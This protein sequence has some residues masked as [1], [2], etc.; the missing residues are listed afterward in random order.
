MEFAF[1][2]VEELAFTSVGAVCL[3]PEEELP[4]AAGNSQLV[5]ASAHFGLVF[6]ADGLGACLHAC[7]GCCCRQCVLSL[8]R[9]RRPSSGV[10][11][12]KVDDL[13]AHC[14]PLKG[15]QSERCAA[16]HLPACERG[17]PALCCASKRPT[18]TVLTEQLSLRRPPLLPDGVCVRHDTQV[19]APLVL[20]S[21]TSPPL[22]RSHTPLTIPGCR[23]TGPVFRRHAAGGAP[24]RRG[25]HPPRGVI[26]AGPAATAQ[27]VRRAAA[28]VP[29][30][31]RALLP[32]CAQA[33]LTP[34]HRVT[35]A[36]RIPG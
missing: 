11:G 27:A 29:L 16:T 23:R 24:R 5:A 7:A 36:A 13:V 26:H 3:H 15:A 14:V 35:Q 10:C 4:Q 19:R 34:F 22:H 28:S 6:F 8:T 21:P 17:P 25:G 32:L 30:L 12:V 2:D 31:V 9:A 1:Q 33:H 20:C 18:C